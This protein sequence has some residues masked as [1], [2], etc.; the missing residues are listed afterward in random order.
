MRISAGSTATCHLCQQ[1]EQGVVKNMV[2][3]LADNTKIG[4]TA[5]SEVDYLT[6]TGS[7]WIGEVVAKELQMELNLDKC[8]VLHFNKP[9]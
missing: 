3:K 8:E 2:S 7:R 1:S 9:G 4:G 6:T 5:D